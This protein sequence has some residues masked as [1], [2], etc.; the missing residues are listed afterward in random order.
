MR[1]VTVMGELA[2][3]LFLYYRKTMEKPLGISVNRV[4]GY[5]RARNVARNI[6]ATLGEVKNAW[7]QA[8]VAPETKARGLGKQSVE[9]FRAAY[10]AIEDRRALRLKELEGSVVLLGGH[11]TH[12]GS[13]SRLY[14]QKEVEAGRMTPEE[15]E[16]TWKNAG[17]VYAPANPIMSFG[18][19]PPYYVEPGTACRVAYVVKPERPVD[20]NVEPVEGIGRWQVFADP[21]DL[22]G[23]R[24]RFYLDELTGGEPAETAASAS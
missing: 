10:E 14:A 7:I 4:I 3:I 1:F 20:P 24:Y 18:E 21:I 8:R 22:E 11:P 9:A 5:V 6:L 13:D 19:E 23:V 2:L 15:F 12:I 16:K 17:H